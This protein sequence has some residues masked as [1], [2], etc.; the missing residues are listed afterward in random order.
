MA[1]NHDVFI[2]S[3]KPDLGAELIT[4]ARTLTPHTGGVVAAIVLGPKSEED[5]AVYAVADKVYCLER[6]SDSVM[7]EDYVPT[8]ARMLQTQKP[9]GLLIGATKRGKA[10]A[11]RL[12]A[13]LGTSVITNA[14]YFVPKGKE[15]QIAHLIFGGRAIRIETNR[16][17]IMLATVE[18]GSFQSSTPTPSGNLETI[19]VEFIEPKYKL[20]VLECKVK[21]PSAMNLAAA[22]KVI[23]VG[24]GV[25]KEEDLASIQDLAKVLTAEI[26][27]TRKL[28]ENISGLPME[29]HI[30][31]SGAYIKP[32]LYVGI[33]VSGQVQ[34]TVGIKDSRV[35]VAINK[36]KNAP[37]FSN[38]DYGIVGDLY[39]VVPELIKVLKARLQDEEKASF[40]C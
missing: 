3:E 4:A 36:D 11:G 5:K 8:I 9:F 39:E 24:C 37:I 19:E 34:H 25:A 35:V 38:A 17:G 32:D 7:V 12:G 23:C 10:V 26:G 14:K 31:I 18:A 22:K 40:K 27:C 30:G 20:T 21:P 13:I 28:G 15:I 33:G 29:R 6:P 2:F 16:S 1:A